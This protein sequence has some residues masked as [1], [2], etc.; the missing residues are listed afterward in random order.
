MQHQKVNAFED[1]SVPKALA[2]FIIPSVVG[3]L[4]TL[5]LNL[6]DAF[7]VGRTEDE[8]QIAAMTITFP[9]V[10]FMTC[11][12]TIFGTGGNAN[13]ASSLAQ[14][15]FAMAKRFS[16]FAFYTSMA[17]ISFI[18]VILLFIQS[19]CL[20]LLGADDTS[21]KYCNGYLLWVLHIPCAAMVGSQVFSQLFVAEGET[22]IASIGI[23]GGGIMNII[24]DPI[25]V[26]ILKQGII[27]AG[28][29][30]CISNYCTLA[31]F[32]VIYFKKR[33]T[34]RL[35][36]HPKY[37]MFRN[38]IAKKT[39]SVGIPA[40][41]S[42]FLMNCSDFVRNY[43]FGIYGGQTELAAWGT[44]QKLSNAFMQIAVGIVQG[45]R[46]LVS[47][48]FAAKAYKRTHALI[49]GTFLIT[50]CYAIFCIALVMLVPNLLIGIFLP[51]E[52]AAPVAVSYF[53]IW[54]PCFLGVCF[55]ELANGIFQAIGKWKISLAGVFCNRIIIYIPCMIILSHVWEIKGVLFSQTISETIT[56]IVL[57]AIY[58][59]VMKKT[60][61]Q[62]TLV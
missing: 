39:L 62:Q 48:N 47:Y 29:A 12:A 5:I 38:G 15:D 49:K 25:F 11:V 2:K 54:I 13:V 18:S 43:F 33:K 20:H 53:Q 14:K 60:E 7:F 42:I 45:C 24:L 58:F 51:V 56:A 46:P 19:P 9:L 36:I 21:I 61:Q 6:T 28:M 17:V 40:G 55:G 34:T 44:V 26:L 32:L 59:Y 3:Q 8:N 1:L 52:E 31:F 50:G 41:L 4:A 27:G 30:T 57:L 37:Y 22:K 35:S 23:A 10:M 16:V